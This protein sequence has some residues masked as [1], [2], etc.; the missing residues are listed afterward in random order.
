MT[1]LEGRKMY[2]LEKLVDRGIER[3]DARRFVDFHAANPDIWKSF[4]YFADKQI[5]EAMHAGHTG[6]IS[7]IELLAVIRRKGTQISKDKTIRKPGT[8]SVSNDFAPCYA[9]IWALKNEQQKHWIDI[10]KTNKQ[11]REEAA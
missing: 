9:R 4:K 6:K 11:K 7:A 3:T 2:Y 10:K 1:T 5:R 8:F